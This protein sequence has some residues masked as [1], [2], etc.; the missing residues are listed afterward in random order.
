MYETFAA[1]PGP[2]KNGSYTVETSNNWSRVGRSHD[3]HP[4]LLMRFSRELAN[5]DRRVLSVIEYRPPMDVEV[6]GATGTTRL[7]LLECKTTDVQLQSY[8]FRIAQTLIFDDPST[9]DEQA[10]T[11]ALDRLISLFRAIQK[12]GTRSVQGVWAELAL[13]RMAPN[14]QDAVLAWHS[15]PHELYDFSNGSV[16][17]EVKSTAK[18]FRE[19]E[20]IL[21]QLGSVD[22][23][24]TLVASMLLR[25][26][27]DGASIVD[28]MNDLRTITR[29]MPGI[30]ERLLG[31]VGES[32]GQG[33][34]TANA[35]KFS[36][37]GARG[38]LRV[39]SG[40]QIPTIP[41]PLPI[42]ITDV[43]FTVK[44]DGMPSLG[45]A[46]ARKMAALYAAILPAPD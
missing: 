46:E 25:E 27:P 29:D 16:R 3:G 34:L 2:T 39:F 14:I 18:P 22:P 8:F 10:F 6:V 13:I 40:D 31:I 20:F 41:Q 42:G 19:H 1:L 21:D 24:M 32:L 11:K 28:L 26:D 12:P 35:V 44:L 30:H 15:N 7:A 5:P 4:V 45:L 43:R 23:G 17:L 33:W 9:E 37:D 38:D 36:L